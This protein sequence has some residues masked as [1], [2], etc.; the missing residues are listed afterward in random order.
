M[1]PFVKHDGYMQDKLKVAKRRLLDTK[2]YTEQL[3]DNHKRDH[4][5][6]E[7]PA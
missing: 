1:F 5:E 6:E 2:A 7:M 3:I 4:V